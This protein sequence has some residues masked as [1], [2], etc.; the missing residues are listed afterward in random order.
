MVPLLFFSGITIANDGGILSLPCE[1]ELSFKFVRQ[2]YLYFQMTLLRNMHLSFIF[3][4]VKMGEV[5]HC[6]STIYLR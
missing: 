4:N 2:S 1:T 3:K 6:K 5:D